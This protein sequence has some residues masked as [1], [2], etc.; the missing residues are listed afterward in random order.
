MAGDAEADGRVEA[1]RRAPRADRH[2]H[3]RQ[4]GEDGGRRGHPPRPRACSTSKYMTKRVKYKAHTEKNEFHIGDTVE[5]VESR[6]MSKDKRWR[7]EK[8][9]E[10]AREAQ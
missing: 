8:L 10:R 5:I 4:D 9:I 7:V 3:V 6:P 2:R 1:P